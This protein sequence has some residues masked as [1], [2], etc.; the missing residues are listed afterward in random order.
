MLPLFRRG[1]AVGRMTHS[2]HA[3]EHQL[4]CI[5]VLSLPR[6]LNHLFYH[7]ATL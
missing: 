2:L 1:L 4:K 6:C 3:Q 5:K 7:S